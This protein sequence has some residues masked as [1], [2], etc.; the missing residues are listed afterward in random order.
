MSALLYESD[1]DENENPAEIVESDTSVEEKPIRKRKKAEII[2]YRK[3]E[4][5]ESEE[6]QGLKDRLAHFS[7]KREHKTAQGLK[8]FY[9]CNIDFQT[10]KICAYVL[11]NNRTGETEFNSRAHPHFGTKAALRTCK[12]PH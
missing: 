2:K 12:K 9:Y 8:K 1:A 4:V 3:E 6:D 7:K 10:C 11:T 5:Y